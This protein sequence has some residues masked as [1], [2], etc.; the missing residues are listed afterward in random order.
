MFKRFITLAVLMTALTGCVI[1]IFRA[2]D[3]G[4]NHRNVEKPSSLAGG[5]GN[6]RFPDL[7]LCAERL[8][9]LERAQLRRVKRGE[10][11]ARLLEIASHEHT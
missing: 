6:S 5:K 3:Y 8:L 1:Q 2:A 10:L 4:T 9:E 7:H 11:Q